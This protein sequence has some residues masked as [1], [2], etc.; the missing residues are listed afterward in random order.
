MLQA[1][2]TGHDGSMTTCHANS[3]IDAFSRLETMVMMGASGVPDKVI[4]QMLT[5]AIHIVIHMTRLHDGSRKITS[6][7]EVRGIEEDRVEIDEI[8]QFERWGQSEQGRSLGAFK[9]SGH[10][11]KVLDRLKAYGVHVSPSMFE[12]VVEVKDR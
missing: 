9:A 6:I 8:F 10:I 4:R 2:N 5:A 3:A 7:C 12:E 11:P 1:M